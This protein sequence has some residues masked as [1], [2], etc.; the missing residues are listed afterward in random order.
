MSKI[1]ISIACFMDNDIVNTIEDCLSKSKFPDNLS[2]GICLQSED[3]DKCLDKYKNNSQFNIKHIHWSHAR[4]PA[5]ARAIIYHMFTDEDYYFQIDCHTRFYEYW[6]TNIIECFKKCKHMN[7]KAIISHYPI[8]INN[9]GKENGSIV[10]ISIVRC[11][12]INM[13]IKTHGRNVGISSCPMKSWG[14]SAAMLF[15]DRKAYNDIPFDKEI[16]FGLQ[17]EEQVVLAA[18]Y[19]THGYDIFTPDKHIIGT[20]YLTNRNRQKKI[21]PR[22]TNL[23]QETYDRLCH[24]MKLKHIYNDDDDELLNSKL[25]DNRTIEEYYKMMNIYDKVKTVFPD[26]YLDK[27]YYDVVFA[28]KV[29]TV[30]SVGFGY[31]FGEFFIRY[32]L[33]LTFPN[34][35][36]NYN[37]SEDC[38]LIIYTHFTQ[39]QYFWNK[40]S[41]PYLLWNGEKYSLPNKI[42]NCSNKLTVDS[43]NL[44]SNMTIPY[45]FFAYVEYKYRNLWL[46]YKNKET[47]NRRLFAYCIS[48]NRGDNIRNTFVETFSN[49]C[50]DVWCIGRYKVNNNIDKVDG[51]WNSD[52]LQKTYSKYKFVLA[53][54]NDVRKGYITEKIINAF[55]SGAI[56]VYIGDSILAKKIFNTKAFICLDDFNNCDDCI[57]Y[58]LNLNDDKIKDF[59]S[60]NIF[61]NEPEADIFREYNNLNANCNKDIVNK[62]KI[63]LENEQLNIY[64]NKLD[65]DIFQSVIINLEKYKEKYENMSNKLNLFNIPYSRF[66]AILGTDIYDNF[67]ATGKFQNN[68]YNL[69]PGQ[70]GCWQSHYKIWQNMIFNNIN[71]LLI[72]EDDCYF[73]NDFKDLY[74][75]TLEMIKDKDYDILFLGYSG[76]NIVI[77]KD[78][79]LL[80]YGVPRCLHAYVLTLSGA[81]KLVEK[82]S[83]ID[84]PIDEIIGRLFHRKELTG[85]R[86]S[87]ILVYQP[88]QKR[89]D[90]YPLPL[91]YVNKYD[92][93]V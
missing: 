4:G 32:I 35:T 91:K 24:I 8:N 80:D 53:S 9:M 5:Y 43:L 65:K 48:A 49:K 18:R 76:S 38:D 6:D 37:N 26:N 51:K 73:V 28:N 60:E 86:T 19:W 58:I 87:Y 3:D 44:N 62:I 31:E 34:F 47:S 39:K 71:K 22:I 52:K 33:S 89:E 2:F 25:G 12:D 46:K 59:L 10:N 56:P 67:K 63:L 74:N 41:K 79:H 40:S 72:F 70:I 77:N 7:E 14:I 13:G 83:V 11:V 20:E 36:I 64:N 17:F 27:N 68:G 82:M 78:L 29:I 84:Y 57:D 90:K 23:Q 1:F 16:Y 15:F 50:D 81:K 88:W 61:T 75:E 66:N 85:Y 21:V 54:E 30:G 42:K 93:L 55:S 69:R 92:D 45:A